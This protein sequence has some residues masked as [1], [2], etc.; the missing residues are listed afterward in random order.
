MA[1]NAPRHYDRSRLLE[2]A[3]RAA[4]GRRRHEAIRCYRRILVVEPQNAEIHRRIAPLLAQTRQP[5]DA[6][7]SFRIA[8]RSLLRQGH[9]ERALAL[10]R[11]AARHLPRNQET[12]G[13]IAR[14]EVKRRRTSHAFD[15]LVE[16]SRKLHRRADRPRA[17]HLLRRALELRPQHLETTLEL[18]RLL[19]RTRR[20]DESQL[21]LESLVARTGGAERRR[22]CTLLLLLFPSFRHV[23]HWL[24]SLP[25]SG[26]PPRP[27]PGGERVVMG[28]ASARPDLPGRVAP[29]G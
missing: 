22:A 20:R 5:F 15:A 10:Y 3:A 11:E 9:E 7:L 27:R 16:G 13:A 4:A 19:Y 14:L 29:A 24:R 28:S 23:W 26:R 17:I 12:W 25:G 21:L 8:A 1:R 18:S 6:W 2:T